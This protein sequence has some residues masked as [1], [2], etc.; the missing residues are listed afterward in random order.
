MTEPM[1]WASLALICA[2]VITW[3]G[4]A[5]MRAERRG[6]VESIMRDGSHY[7]IQRGRALLACRGHLLDKRTRDALTVWLAEHDS[8]GGQK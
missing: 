8:E 6:E 3:A 7:A 4:R 5:F 2:V 1:F